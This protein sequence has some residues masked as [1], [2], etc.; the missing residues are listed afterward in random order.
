[1]RGTQN[2]LLEQP[3]V[4]QAGVANYTKSDMGTEQI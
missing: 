4:W 2:P 1:M 3:T